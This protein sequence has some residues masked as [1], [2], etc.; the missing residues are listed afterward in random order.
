MRFCKGCDNMQ[1]IVLRGGPTA[2]APDAAFEL[3][4]AC[5][6]CGLSEPAAPDG[7]DAL[8][9]ST[10]Y[11]DDKTSYMQYASPY[12]RHDPTL[13]RVSDIACPNA[14]CSRPEGALN[15]VIYVKYDAVKLKYLYH[16]AH[17]ATFWKSGGG[18][19]ADTAAAA[20]AAVAA[21]AAASASAAAAAGS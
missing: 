16:C 3:H 19:V 21:V 15:E 12:I 4:F 18:V 14:K 7:G 17:C 6:H 10:D 5:K 9:M 11:S 13:P 8:I 1:E 20:V 2:E